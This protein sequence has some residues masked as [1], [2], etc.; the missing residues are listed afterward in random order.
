MTGV[1][2]CALP[3]CFPVTIAEVL[4]LFEFPRNLGEY[5][6]KAV[7]VG[8][9]RFGPYVKHAS[10][11]VS[12]PKTDSPSEINLERAIELIE[13][14][15]K[16]DSEKVIKTFNEEPELQVLNGRFGPYIAFNGANYKIP[17]TTDPK[18]LTLEDCRT[19]VESQATT[20]KAKPRAKATGS[21]AT[22]AKAKASTTKKASSK[23]APPKKTTTKKTK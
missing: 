21:K 14:K 20:V 8:I 9:G 16:A 17:K 19:I 2:T 22:T 5:E 11:Y 10:K 7:Q 23:T 18:A 3:I 6:G 1:Q 13:A 12:I 15:R 4:K